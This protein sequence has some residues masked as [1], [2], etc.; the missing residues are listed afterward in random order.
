MRE[1]F[2]KI[3]IHLHK[4]FLLKSKKYFHSLTITETGKLKFKREIKVL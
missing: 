4:K 1:L 2:Y 3:K